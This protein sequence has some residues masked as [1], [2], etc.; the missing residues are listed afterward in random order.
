[1]D[2]VRVGCWL[3]S[4]AIK[5]LPRDYQSRRFIENAVRTGHIEVDK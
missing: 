3:I 4:L 2:R 1:M 5:A